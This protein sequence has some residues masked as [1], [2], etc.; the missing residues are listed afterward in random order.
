MYSN[1]Y[2]EL[3]YPPPSPPPPIYP[4]VDSSVNDL[5]EYFEEKKIFQS[6]LMI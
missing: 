3:T 6:K 5:S 4:I 1:I 2:E